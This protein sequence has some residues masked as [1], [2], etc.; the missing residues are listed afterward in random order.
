M[1]LIS[2]TQLGWYKLHYAIGQ[3]SVFLLTKNYP[4]LTLVY[5]VPTTLNGITIG[6][7]L[8]ILLRVSEHLPL[9]FFSVTSAF[10]EQFT[11]QAS[12]FTSSWTERASSL[13][14]QTKQIDSSLPFG[15]FGKDYIPKG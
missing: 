4:P 7:G 14:S 6:F 8:L 9:V 15:K 13:F 3:S 11:L 12:Y 5:C 10:F 1:F 2:S